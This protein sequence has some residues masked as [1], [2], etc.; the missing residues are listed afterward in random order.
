MHA[1][2]ILFYQLGK[3]DKHFNLGNCLQELGWVSR[4]Q[5]WHSCY[6]LWQE[7]NVQKLSS[8]PC[9]TITPPGLERNFHDDFFFL[10]KWGGRFRMRWTSPFSH[11]PIPNSGNPAYFCWWS[12]ANSNNQALTSF[13]PFFVSLPPHSLLLSGLWGWG[14]AL[15]PGQHIHRTQGSFPTWL[16]STATSQQAR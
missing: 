15:V 8:I 13:W 12:Y 1:V 10:A 6:L 16:C 14:P 4:V 3:I 7:Q 11:L 5:W 2:K 9:Y